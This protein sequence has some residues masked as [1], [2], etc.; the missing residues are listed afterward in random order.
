[1][2]NYSSALVTG[3][4]GDIGY[5]IGKML[6]KNGWKV[7]GIDIKEMPEDYHFDGYRKCDLANPEECEEQISHLLTGEIVDVVVNCA[8]KIVNSPFVSLKN[9][10]FVAHDFMLWDD[11][12]KSSLYST[13]NV[14]R[15]IVPLWIKKRKKGTIINFSSISATGNPGQIAYSASKVAIETMTTVL[16]KELSPFGIRVS[17]IAP[18]FIDTESTKNNVSEDQLKKIRSKVPLKELGNLEDVWNTV[19]FIINTRYINGKT[20]SLDGGLTL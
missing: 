3:I 20:I 15:S 11:A 2:D 12:I 8:G 1:M 14:C 6:Q 18:G 9:G 5:Y 19:N 10:S 7:F 17:T 16:S 4:C 13:F